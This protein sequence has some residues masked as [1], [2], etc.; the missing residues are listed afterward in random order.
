[1]KNGLDAQTSMN[2]HS[3]STFIYIPS[4]PAAD[5]STLCEHTDVR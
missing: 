2:M 3:G 4:L 1:M 5:G